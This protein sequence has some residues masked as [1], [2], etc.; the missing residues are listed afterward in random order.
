MRS[1]LKVDD[2]ADWAVAVVAVGES[3][4]F[5][6]GAEVAPGPVLNRVRLL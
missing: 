5:G 2:L 6:P 3:G 4:V 1:E